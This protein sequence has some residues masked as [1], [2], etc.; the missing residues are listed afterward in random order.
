MIS[1]A[2]RDRNVSALLNR[3]ITD[4]MFENE[5]ALTVFRF[6]KRHFTKYGEV[7]T[8]VTV[9][10]NFPTI[11]VLKVEDTLDYCVDQ[12]IAYHQNSAIH[13]TIQKAGR[14]YKTTNDHESVM[15][16]LAEGLAKAQSIGFQNDGSN[17]LDL[18]DDPLARWEAYEHLREHPGELLGYS[19]GFPTID[20]ATGGLQG[21]QLIVLM[22]LPKVGK[23]AILLKSATQIHADGRTPWSIT[24]EMTNRE[25]MTRHDAFRARISHTRLVRGE[26]HQDEEKR[27]RDTLKAMAK[28]HPFYMADATQAMTVPG[29]AAKVSELPA[30]PDAIFIDGAY[31]IVDHVSGEVNTPRALTNVTR[32]LKNFALKIDRPVFITTQAL[33]WKTKGGKLTPGAAGY[34]SSFHQDADVLMGLERV[35][36]DENSRVL[37][38]LDSR[39]CGRLEVDLLW[40]WDTG[41]FQEYQASDDESDV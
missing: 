8:A 27:L 5:D 20:E 21:G 19:T 15:A 29:I 9:V 37:K 38:I 2:I 7:P 26:L 22:A 1:K 40:D 34:S 18:T 3:G 41:T 16:I 31:F 24:F 30:L 11:G 35:E 17:D 28:E 39:N 36:E 23:S 4:E 32:G 13:D 12:F 10:D 6:V 25:Q 33:E 14:L